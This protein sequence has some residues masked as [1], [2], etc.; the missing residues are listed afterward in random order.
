[1]SCD[2]GYQ[3]QCCC[4]CQYQVELHCHPSNERLGKGST[5]DSMNVY[6]CI[7]MY[8]D[9]SNKGRATFMDREHGMC[10]LHQEKQYYA[11]N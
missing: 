10:E 6:A 1:M 4:N 5:R 9:E 3:G 2:K 11:N 8:E 7:A